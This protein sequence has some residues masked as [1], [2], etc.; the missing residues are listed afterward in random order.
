MRAHGVTG[1]PDHTASAPSSLSGYSA[2]IR[3]GVY[4]AIP[5]TI[6]MAS[7]SYRRAAAACRLGPAFS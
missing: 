2:V 5:D 7:P 6:N 1:F 3:R 4:L